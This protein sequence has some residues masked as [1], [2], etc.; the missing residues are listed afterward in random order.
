MSRQLVLLEASSREEAEISGAAE[1]ENCPCLVACFSP[2]R[3]YNKLSVIKTLE[4]VQKSNV[5]I[6][7]QEKHEYFEKNEKTTCNSEKNLLY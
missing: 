4:K 3:L 7:V 5:F 1:T 2:C 6:K